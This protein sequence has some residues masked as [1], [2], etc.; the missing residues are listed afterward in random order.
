MSSPSDDIQFAEERPELSVPMAGPAFKVLIVDDD[1]DVHTATKQV[2]R[3]FYSATVPPLFLDAYS[4]AEA[5]ALLLKQ[6]DIAVILLDVVME[7]T[8]AGLKLVDA[9]RGDLDLPRTQIILRTGQPGHAAERTVI[10][11]FDINGYL[12]KSALTPERL[13]AAIT[14]AQRIYRTLT[15]QHQ[16]SEAIEALLLTSARMKGERP[17]DSF[18]LDTMFHIATI[19]ETPR[20]GFLLRR[21]KESQPLKVMTATPEFDTWR[22]LA[23]AELQDQSLVTR[24]QACLEQKKSV[25]DA[26]A[27]T[28]FVRGLRFPNAVIHMV[29]EVD[30]GPIEH[31]LLQT[32]ITT[33]VIGSDVLP[34]D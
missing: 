18:T 8:D 28:L 32:L 10:A 33:Y 21:T 29:R 34:T 20:K 27:A 25:I 6:R 26:S 5:H 17:F 11:D 22:G 31:R 23:I 9:I 1:P 4:A 15:K 12:P 14:A 30:S 13:F 19:L 3:T 24:V 16:V 2:L 7:S